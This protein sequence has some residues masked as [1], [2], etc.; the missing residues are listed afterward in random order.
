MSIAPQAEA[1][2]FSRVAHFLSRVPVIGNVV[3]HFAD[4]RAH[5]KANDTI[6]SYYKK[7]L[8]CS[9]LETDGSSTAKDLMKIKPA[10][11][12]WQSL[13]RL[14]SVANDAKSFAESK[15]D[16]DKIK[17]CYA[18]CYIRNQLGRSS[19]V[20][21]AFLKELKDASDC[22]ANTHFEM[23]DYYATLAGVKAGRYETCQAFC[24]SSEIANS[25]GSQMLKAARQLQ[26]TP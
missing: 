5:D 2:F 26:D 13:E 4:N 14:E 19:G 24:G 1:G 18:G 15:S 6:E 10:L 25:T 22:K 21:V 17:H 12:T 9:P 23:Q 7:A 16:V 8:S 20:L 3:D 11:P